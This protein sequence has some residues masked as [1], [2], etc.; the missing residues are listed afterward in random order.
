MLPPT[1]M[2]SGTFCQPAGQGS[3]LYALVFSLQK[4]GPFPPSVRSSGRNSLNSSLPDTMYYP[5]PVVG[6]LDIREIRREKKLI[7]RLTLCCLKSFSH[8]FAG[9]SY[10]K[11]GSFRLLTHRLLRGP[12]PFEHMIFYLWTNSNEICT[13]Y[14]K[15]K[16]N[17]ILFLKIFDFR[18]S[19]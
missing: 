8:C 11:L 18:F 4:K 10:P 15:L 3:V 9:H 16:I 17:H 7:G 6:G 13:A 2:V 12:T 19:L 5:P 14:V 1:G